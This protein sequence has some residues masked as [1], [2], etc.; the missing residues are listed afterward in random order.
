MTDASASRMVWF[1][2][3]R[4]FAAI[5]VVLIHSTADFSG[6]A[7]SQASVDERIV[8]VLLRTLGEFS[9]SEMFFTFSLFLLAYKL[10]RRRPAY[11]AEVADQMRRLLVPFAIWTIFY[12][13]F[14]L[15]KATEFGYADAIMG[16][17]SAWQSWLGY[18]LLGNAQY[19]LHFLPTLFLLVLFFPVMRLGQR[20]PVAGLLVVAT[21]CVMREVQGFLWG[22]PLSDLARDYLL[23]GVKVMGYVGY[24]LA[25]FSLYGLWKDGIPRGEA[26]LIRLGALFLAAL[27][28]LATVP[29]IVTVIATGDWGSRVGLSF[30]GHFL[31]PLAVF[32]IF[33]GSQYA[34]WSPRWSRIAR[35]TFGVYLMHPMVI[36]LFDVT[37]HASGLVLSPAELVLSRMATVLP[38]TFGLAVLIGSLPRLA[39]TIGLGPLPWAVERKRNAVAV[40]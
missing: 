4:V 14:R 18:F 35:Y 30:Y 13:V 11:G 24:G 10:D 31:M 40:A 8:P 15:L 1:D 17:L 22:L 37:L 39:W 12:A 9:G 21:L 7:F 34:A 29:H 33:I 23:R 28:L 2:A 27:A 26:K 32:A 16:Q 5:G 3:N 25:A 36:D 6:G 19:H 20:F 38:V